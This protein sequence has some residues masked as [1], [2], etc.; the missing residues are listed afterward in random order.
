MYAFGI[1]GS[2]AMKDPIIQE[3]WKIKDRIAKECGNDIDKLARRLKEKEKS[4]RP[5]NLAKSKKANR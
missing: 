4:R 2:I 3:L 1:N 5:V